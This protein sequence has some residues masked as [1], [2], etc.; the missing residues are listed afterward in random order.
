MRKIILTDAQ[1]SRLRDIVND[2]QDALFDKLTVQVKAQR[3]DRAAAL[4]ESLAFWDKID[5]AIRDSQSAEQ[6]D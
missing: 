4:R 5:V 2:K 3:E 1:A 6:S